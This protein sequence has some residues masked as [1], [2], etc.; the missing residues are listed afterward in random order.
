M[1]HAFALR[2]ERYLADPIADKLVVALVGKWPQELAAHDGAPQWHKMAVL[3]KILGHCQTLSNA[4]LANWN[5]EIHGLD[6]Q[7]KEALKEF[8]HEVSKLPKWANHQKIEHAG[9]MARRT[10]A[11][12]SA[13]LFTA[14]QPEVYGIRS[15]SETL[16]AS[17]V[18]E[19]QTARRIKGT[20]ELVLPVILKGGMTAPE[21]RGLAMIARARLMH[22]ATR[23]LIMRGEPAEVLAQVGEH[24]VLPKL[25]SAGK[26]AHDPFRALHDAGYNVAE[27]GVP[28]HQQDMGFVIQSFNFVPLRSYRK[29]GMGLHHRDEDALTHAWNVVGHC[30]GLGEQQMAHDYSTSERMFAERLKIGHAPAPGPDPRPAH[31]HAHL[32]AMK[33]AFPG[34]RGHIPEQLMHRLCDPGT[35]KALGMEQRSRVVASAFKGGFNVAKTGEHLC[36]K[37]DLPF[38]PHIMTLQHMGL[39]F[40]DKILGVNPEMLN[41]LAPDVN[42]GLRGRS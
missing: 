38:S 35:L 14:S 9:E 29:L 1:N 20:S 5:G 42:K 36:R 10:G 25:T 15:I 4:E 31:G 34:T 33:H 39:T 27:F 41:T 16:I 19:K 23:N 40:A 7:G 26:G 22:A 13:A 2:A 12:Y 24:A 28:V 37:F 3:G 8:F 18:S 6:A 11:V 21:G 30:I 17:G 32:A